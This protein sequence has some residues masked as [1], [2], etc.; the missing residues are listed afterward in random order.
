V[1]GRDELRS[2][3]ES[4]APPEV[5]LVDWITALDHATVAEHDAQ[6]Y[7]SVAGQALARCVVA[8][9]PDLLAATGASTVAATLEA[10]QAFVDGPTEAA[11]EDYVA[12]ATQSYPYGPGDGCLAIGDRPC[13]DPG[14]GCRSGAG[15][16]A[17]VAS[18]IGAGT[19]QARIVA[20]LAPWLQ[21]LP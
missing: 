12:R 2:L 16:L 6:R 1:T 3:V 7:G 13:A 15:T 14:S 10:A 8:V 18:V 20:A 4:P 21:A 11:W 19:V 9:G 17:Q 5:W